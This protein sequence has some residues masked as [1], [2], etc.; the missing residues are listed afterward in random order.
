MLLANGRDVTAEPFDCEYAD[1]RL[2]AAAPDLLAALHYLLEQTVDADLAY[3]VELT[4]GETEARQMALAAI[5][6][7]TGEDTNA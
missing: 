7:A 3:G 5:A 2:M 6:N 4:E 1:A